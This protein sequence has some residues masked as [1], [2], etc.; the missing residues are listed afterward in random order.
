MKMI[1]V[2]PKENKMRS[3]TEV[4]SLKEVS[5]MAAQSLDPDT[6][7]KFCAVHD[8]LVTIRKIPLKLLHVFDELDK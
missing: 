8:A 3:K 7:E 4:E 2:K 1:P 6:Y 5:E